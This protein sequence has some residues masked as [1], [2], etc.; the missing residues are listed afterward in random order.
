MLCIKKT[1]FLSSH[2]AVRI[3]V[4]LLGT[5]RFVWP[6]SSRSASHAGRHHLDWVHLVTACDAWTTCSLRLTGRLLPLLLKSKRYWITGVART[7][8]S[9]DAWSAFESGLYFRAIRNS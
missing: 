8:R 6:G 9:S 2:F 5:G 1:N 7:A 4:C 3:A